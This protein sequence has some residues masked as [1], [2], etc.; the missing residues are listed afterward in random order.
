M[1]SILRCCPVKI[2]QTP[3]NKP[4]T[5]APGVI[6]IMSFVQSP[7]PATGWSVIPVSKSN[8]KGM[9]EKIRINEC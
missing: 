4:E 7:V 3:L 2:P 6:V 8:L 9:E 1:K 5:P